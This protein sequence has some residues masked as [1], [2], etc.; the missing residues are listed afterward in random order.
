MLAMKAGPVFLE[1][2]QDKSRP[3]ERDFLN[4]NYCPRI[5]VRN[6]KVIDVMDLEGNRIG[7]F[8]PTPEN[9]K[10]LKELDIMA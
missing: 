9:V 1:T 6:D 8:K 3:E 10:T 2:A 5:R 7:G 4:L